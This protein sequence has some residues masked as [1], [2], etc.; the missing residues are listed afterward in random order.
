[1]HNTDLL[2]T[3]QV[4]AITG[5]SLATINRKVAAGELRVELQAPGPR[6]AR[7]YHPAEVERFAA[8]LIARAESG[9]S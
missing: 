5:L 7:L 8:S 3:A 2:S 1:M 4:A 9:T 6:G